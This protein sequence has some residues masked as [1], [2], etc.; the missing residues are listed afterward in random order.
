M[1]D[2]AIDRERRRLL[3]AMFDA[4]I[5]AAD[6]ATAVASN[7][8]AKPRGRCLVVGAGKASAAM[9]AALEAAW[10]DVAIEGIVSTRHGHAVPCARIRIVEAGHPVP[11]ANSVA[12]ADAMLDLLRSAGP[13]DLVLALMSGGGSACLARPAHGVTL[14]D[15]QAITAGLLRSGAPISQ[16]NRV[17]KALSSVK[18][19]RL[20]HA[21]GAAPVW[22]LVI[23]DVPGDDPADVASGPTIAQ[24]AQIEDPLDILA[25]Y[26]IV[27]PA[28]VRGALLAQQDRPL[29]NRP[30]DHVRVIASPAQSLAAAAAMARA[31]GYEVANLGDRVEGEAAHVAATHAELA[32]RTA[33]EGRGPMAILSGGETT[34]TLPPGCAGSGGRN[35]EYQLALAR[36]LG[37]HPNIWAIAGDSDGIDGASEAAGA[38]GAPDTLSRAANAGLDA[39]KALSA[40]ASGD[41]FA[42]LG[43]LVITGPT[44]TN[45]NDIRI[46]LIG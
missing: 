16:I 28:H 21:A 10:P 34:V 1:Q 43:D 24:G 2:G 40:H 23:S 19:G 6:P 13:D 31:N 8:P 36:A 15:K 18:G 35:T 5:A 42:A 46:Q 26:D 30:Q 25:R 3:R 32:L 45:V 37:G 33:A 41:Y 17:R 12:A 29:P 11:D 14:A 44:H 27:V 22:S 38:I 9:A 7:L 39:G 4:A 20:A